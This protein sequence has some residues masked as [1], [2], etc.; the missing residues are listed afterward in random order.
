LSS[1]QVPLRNL[2]TPGKT[3]RKQMVITKREKLSTDKSTNQ[4]T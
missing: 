4:I 3:T 1:E 2:I